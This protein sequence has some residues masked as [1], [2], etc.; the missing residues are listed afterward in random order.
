VDAFGAV[1]RE[2]FVSEAV[3]SL[4]YNDWSLPIFEGQTISQ[5]TLVARMI[6]L[7]DIQ[8]QD[9]LLDVGTGC[10]YQAAILSRLAKEVITVERVAA[11]AESARERLARLQFDNV[12]VEL[13]GDTLGR[14]QDAPYDGII[15][16]AA[17]PRVPDDLYEQLS[18]GARLVIPVGDRRNQIVVLVTRTPDGPEK[19]MLENCAFVPLIG[20]D[21]WA[22]R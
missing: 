4:A 3:R 14:P 2:E 19:Q 1:P 13:A 22:E 9:R 11:L 20:E 7:L 12:R 10:G 16:G 15:V 8:S 21:A 5:P 6:Q 17:A 18:I